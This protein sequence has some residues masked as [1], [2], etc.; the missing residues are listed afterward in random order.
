MK[1]TTKVR[2][3]PSPTGMLHL[4]S[5]R[6]ALFNYIFAKSTG[7]E[8]LLR[9]EDTDRDRSTDAST[10]TILDGLSWLGIKWDGD[11]VFQSTRYARHREAAE[12]MIANGSAYFAY[13]TKEEL[14]AERILADKEGRQYRYSGKWRNDTTHLSPPQGIDPVVRIKIPKGKTIVRDLIRGDMEFDNSTLDDFIILR[15]DGTPTYMLAVVVDD[16][17]MGITHVIRGDDHISNTPKQI[18]IY[19]AL[20][21]NLPSFAHIPLIHNDKGEKLSKRRNAVAIS[22]YEALGI[23]P[24]AMKNYLLSLGWSYEGSGVISDDEAGKIFRL[25][26]IGK[27]PS[28]FDLSKLY[29]LNLQYI[30]SFDNNELLNMIILSLEGKGF[31]I[32][33][34]LRKR[35]EV[36]IPEL[37]KCNNLIDLTS[38]AMRYVVDNLEYSNEAIEII[39]K[40]IVLTSKVKDFIKITPFSD[41][42]SEWQGFLD[43]NGFKFGQVGPILRSMLIGVSSSTALTLIV[44]ALGK[45][46]CKRRVLR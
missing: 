5:A 28:R 42:K 15:S 34:E 18:L 24:E 3:A 2:F 41:F 17:D 4:G 22:D 9:I 6:T 14:E 1:K 45:E 12:K 32:N 46:E 43:E 19:E 40:D 8:F 35:V 33:D 20:G 44:E 30:Q 38:N 37:K 16:I 31:K 26:N 27:S 39:N 10:K 36:V 7:G 13:D 29:N 25:E 21:A 23:L 11:I